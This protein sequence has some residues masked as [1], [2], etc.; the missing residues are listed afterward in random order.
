MRCDVNNT[1]FLLKLVLN[2]WYQNEK[3]TIES[4]YEEEMDQISRPKVL[5]ITKPKDAGQKSKG[6]VAINFNPQFL[7]PQKPLTVDLLEFK[8]SDFWGVNK[9]ILE[10]YG[11]SQMMMM[12]MMMSAQV[13]YCD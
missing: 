9:H 11:T 6:A 2:S 12:M 7:H 5:N 13:M 1:F 8:N 10:I 4:Q 3:K